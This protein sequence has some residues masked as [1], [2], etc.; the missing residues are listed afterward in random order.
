MVLICG[1]CPALLSQAGVHEVIR[2][3][4]PEVPPMQS[5][6]LGRSAD[7]V[8]THE[9]AHVF[10]SLK[11]DVSALQSTVAVLVK[12]L[13]QQET[14]NKI[15]KYEV[16]DLKN[17]VKDLKAENKIIKAENKILKVEN[18]ILKDEVKDLK[19]EVK[20]L[21]DEVKALKAENKDLNSENK[22]GKKRPRRESKDNRTP[23]LPLT[24]FR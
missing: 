2:S 14:E 23:F 21:K 11:A 15:L 3:A 4:V 19:N 17:E 9:Q 8:L 13:E 10:R 1:G 7:T 20:G 22:K 16:K 24:K 12:R 6:A 5:Q 18:Q